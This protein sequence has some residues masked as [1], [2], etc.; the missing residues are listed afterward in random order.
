MTRMPAAAIA[1]LGR[2]SRLLSLSRR[3]LLAAAVV[4]LVV[5][6][7]P[8]QAAPLPREKPASLI[9]AEV[10]ARLDD[11]RVTTSRILPATDIGDLVETGG[12]PP[13]A[14]VSASPAGVYSS[15]AAAPLPRPAPTERPASAAAPVQLAAAPS[16]LPASAVRPGA[17]AKDLFGAMRAPAPLAA[18]AI[19]SYARGCLAGATALAVDGPTWQVMR[20]SRNRNWGH[21]HLVAMLQRLAGDA[22]SLGWSGLL[23]GDLA[24]PRGGPMT[25]GHSSHQIGL[26][27]DIWL[28]PMPGRTLSREE[29]ETM[30]AISM[31]KGPSELPGADRGV[32]PAK[33][34]DSHARLIRRAAQDPQVS[35]IF[36]HPGI[37]QALCRF[38]TGE[39]GWLR[40]IRPWWGHHYHFHVRIA[41]PDGSVGCKDQDPPPP[42][43]GCGAELASWLSDEPWVPKK[44]KKTDK[45]VAPAKKKHMTLSALPAACTEVL[46]AR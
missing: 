37:K 40:K 16:G 46:V 45:P 2:P 36:V 29:R 44:P 19:G 18:R 14:S 30:T 22:P 6:V 27:A 3:P 17:V 15:F 25:S 34:T 12:Q 35:R 23:V 28:T 33:W 38:E 4:A 24:Q 1:G 32:D 9:A 43:D 21:P 7:A 13:A 8:L 42:G 26:D 11:R 31:L 41:C 10:M 39:R 20:L 5:P